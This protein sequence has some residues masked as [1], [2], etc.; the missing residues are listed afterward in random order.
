ML[1]AAILLQFMLR[2]YLEAAVIAVLHT[3]G[4]LLLSYYEANPDLQMPTNGRRPTIPFRERQSQKLDGLPDD[5]MD[6][7]QTIP[8]DVHELWDKLQSL[9]E[10]PVPITI[11][12]AGNLLP[13]GVQ[14]ISSA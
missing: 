10:C 13:L 4:I 9:R 12:D 11:R 1:E 3:P 7:E 8:A 2:E 6:L 5:L 14:T